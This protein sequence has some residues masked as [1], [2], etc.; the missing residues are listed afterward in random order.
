MRE[1]L[2]GKERKGKERKGKDDSAADSEEM[3]PAL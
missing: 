3:R 2:T 1:I